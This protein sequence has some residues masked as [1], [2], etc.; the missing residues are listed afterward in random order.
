MIAASDRELAAQRLRKR[1]PDLYNHIQLARQRPSVVRLWGCSR[2]FDEHARQTIVDP[3]ILAVLSDLTGI[4]MEGDIL[5]AGLQHTYG[6]LFSLIETPFGFKRDRWTNGELDRAFGFSSSV[7]HAIPDEGTLLFNATWFLGRIAF[8][9][10]RREMDRLRPLRS[11]VDPALLDFNYRRLHV[12]RLTE[13]FFVPGTQKVQI[14][15]VTD[16]VRYPQMMNQK[17]SQ[18]SN[19]ALLTYSLMDNREQTRK[20]ITAFPIS[21]ETIREL[22][23]PESL[24]DRQ[25]IKLSYNISIPG[26]KETSPIGSRS[27][28]SAWWTSDEP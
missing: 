1:L 18:S 4:E 17:R 8:R 21:Q 14:S 27:L 13:S 10:C 12:S 24:G 25:T 20:L 6:Y 19:S 11:R 28:S 7:L 2:N 22:T 23:Q 26:L 15:L 9:G 3:G 5:H 16:F